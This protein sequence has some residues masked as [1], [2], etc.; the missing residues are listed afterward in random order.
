[1]FQSGYTIFHSN[2][3]NANSC[4]CGLM[5]S[6]SHLLLLVSHDYIIIVIIIIGVGVS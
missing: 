5:S 6:F 3:V 1:M 2:Q 4:A